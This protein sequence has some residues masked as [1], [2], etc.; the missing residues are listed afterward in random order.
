VST[1]AFV[2]VEALRRNNGLQSNGKKRVGGKNSTLTRGSNPFQ[3]I[4]SSQ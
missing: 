1:T 2:T 4:R 3:R